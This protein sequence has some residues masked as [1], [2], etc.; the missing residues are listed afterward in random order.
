MRN[1]NEKA[2]VYEEIVDNIGSP[3]AAARSSAGGDWLRMPVL[4]F[5]GMKG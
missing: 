1:V 5:A 3:A 4:T 2:S